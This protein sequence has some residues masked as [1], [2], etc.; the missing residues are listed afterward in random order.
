MFPALEITMAL[1]FRM[2]GSMHPKLTLELGLRWDYSL[3]PAKN[4]AAGNFVPG[5]P[6]R[7]NFDPASRKTDPVLFTRFVGLLQKDGINLL[8]R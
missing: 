5:A 1:V 3:R 2:I 8:I 7:L 6:G 4:T